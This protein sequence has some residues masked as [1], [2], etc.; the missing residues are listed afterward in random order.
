MTELALFVWAGVFPLFHSVLVATSAAVM[1]NLFSDRH[2]RS[3]IIFIASMAFATCSRHAISLIGMVTG[4]ALH[5][6][7]A[8]YMLQAGMQLVVERDIPGLP[9]EHNNAL[10]GRNFTAN[11]R[12]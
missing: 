6:V 3:R 12:E 7:H 1:E 10:I 9:L 4:A 8:A 11:C 2:I 5:F